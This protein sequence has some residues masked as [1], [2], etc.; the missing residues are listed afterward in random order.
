MKKQEDNVKTNKI[1]HRLSIVLD[2]FL[3]VAG[4]C[5]LAVSGVLIY[6]KVYLTPFWVNGQ[7]MYPF[8]NAKAMSSNGK[9]KGRNGG[10]TVAGDYMVDYGVMDTH[11]SALKKIKRFDIIVTRYSE[12][13]TSKKI[14]R[15]IGL[16]G[17]TIKF[18]SLTPGDEHNGDLYV[19]EGDKFTFVEQPVDKEYVRYGSKYPTSEIVLGSDE[20]YVVGDNRI[21]NNSSDSR[22]RGPIKYSYLIGKVVALCGYGEI[23]QSS[24]GHNDIYNVKYYWP[25]Y[26]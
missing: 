9:E 3:L 26:I 1:R 5:A 4:L 7:S 19:K 12:T 6:Q 10:S 11:E 24:D 8:L 2:I 22:E 18:T 13:D 25:R 23:K 21:G 20:Y 14:K 15:V 16:P 17:E